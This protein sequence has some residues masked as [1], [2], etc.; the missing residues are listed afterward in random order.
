MDN[1]TTMKLNMDKWLLLALEEDITSEDITTNA[2]MRENKLGEAQLLC[3]QDG[4]IA[5]L[6]VFARVFTLLDENTKVEL[7]FQDGDK[8]KNG[9]L[10]A[11]VKGDI[12]VILSGER[13]ALNYLQRMS[14]IATH[15]RSLVDLLS[16]SKTKLLDTRKTTPNMR[17][18]E[19]YAVK[20]G[21]GYNHRYNLS[22]GIL[23][24]DNHIGAAGGVKQAVA[25][26][27]EYAPFVRKIEV[28]VENL[29][30]LREALEAG[31][32]IIM[33][34][35]MDTETMKKAVQIVDGRAETECSGNVTKERVADI[36]S[37]GVDYVSCGALTHSSPILDVSLKNLHRI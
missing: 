1:L 16:G 7:F 5:G 10:L 21:G 19:K 8:V 11:K 24:K 33:L 25:M 9:D 26:A 23:I 14:G 30:M 3:K 28:E 15:T 4:I 31:A 36:I 18:F 12:R 29:D 37:T 17:I 22:D 6:N 2:I 35:N 32:D 13:T 27:K 34:D 20:V